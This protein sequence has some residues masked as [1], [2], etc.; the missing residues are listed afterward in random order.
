MRMNGWTV[1]V[2]LAGLAGSASRL[3]PAEILSIAGSASVDIREIRSGEEI[4]SDQQMLSFP[5]TSASLP[6]QVASRLITTEEEAAGAVAAQFADPLTAGGGNPEEFAI[7][8]A[9]DSLSPRYQFTAHAVAEEV[10][11]VQFS[12]SEVTPPAGGGPATVRGRLFL[13]GALAV[14]AV[15]GVTDLSPVA[16]AMHVTI[17]KEEEGQSPA[18]VF[19]GLLQVTGDSAGKVNVAA[20]GGFPRSGLFDANLADLDPQLGVFRVI[21]LPNLVLSYPYE[22]TVGQPFTLR[23]TVDV[24]AANAPSGVG[25]AAL[26]GT[27][28]ETLQ[29]VLTLTQGKTLA[30]K[31]IAAIENERAVPSGRDV[32]TNETAQPSR[33][34][35]PMCGL[36]GLESLV[37]LVGLLGLRRA[38]SSRR[39]LTDPYSAGHQE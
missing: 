14:F 20:T 9:L 30:T 33:G 29:K 25:V 21:V 2:I 4:D 16:L 26:L 1:S 39:H 27:P 28:I 18:T 22:A 5:D 13:D 10:R 38:W 24:Q 12:A 19:D 11:G 3:A 7:N 37:G 17:V 34:L 32:F 36:F 23:A 35:F 31:M 15:N 8:L 6:L